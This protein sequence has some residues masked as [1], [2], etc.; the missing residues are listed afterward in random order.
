MDDYY[1][2]VGIFRSSKTYYGTAVGPD[3]QLGGELI[4]LPKSLD[5][6]VFYKAMNPEEIIRLKQDKIDLI[7]KENEAKAKAAQAAKEGKDPSEF[8]SLQMAVGNIWRKG[9]ID[10][11][12]ALVD[13]KGNPNAMCMGVTEGEKIENSP[14]YERGELA[15]PRESKVPRGFPEVVQLSDPPEIPASE[16]GRLQYAQWLTHPDHPLTARVIANRVWNHLFR[17]GLVRTTDNFGFN[18]ERPS[19][20]EL[21]DYLALKLVN[22]HKWSVKG[23][24]RELVLTRSYRQSS[25]FRET[26]FLKDPENRLLWRMSKRRLDAEE[27]RDAML[28]VAGD[29]DLT[30]PVA[31]LIGRTGD[32]NA[33]LLPFAKNIPADLDGSVHRSVYLPVVRDRLPDVLELF[34]FAESSLVTGHRETT[35]VPMQALYFMNSVF[36]EERST[37]FAQRVTTDAGNENKARIGTAFQL[38]FNRLPT[39]EESALAREFF[40]STSGPDSLKRYC[41]ALLST[42]TFRNL[43]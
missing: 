16:S 41:Q 10:G 2:M 18:G 25:D 20:P 4:H 24:I 37:S 43:D 1:A 19:H 27:I 3:N 9:A 15:T 6:P 34:D 13:E 22:E 7:A 39:P 40:E 11:K 23:L 29:L 30:R 35:N 31:S 17:T 42:A 36:V 38:C 5:L 26:S 14:V 32:R 33:A 28:F 8:F 21:L 12:L